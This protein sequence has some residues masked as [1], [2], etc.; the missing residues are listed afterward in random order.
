MLKCDSDELKARIGNDSRVRIGKL[1]DLDAVDRSLSKYDLRSA[2]PG[3]E[4]LVID[5]TNFTAEDATDRIIQ[6]FAL[7][8]SN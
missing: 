5:T 1:V 3:R 2:Y 8:I 6:H 4:S 7:P